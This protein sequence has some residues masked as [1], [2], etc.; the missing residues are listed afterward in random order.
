MHLKR[1]TATFI[2]P[3]YRGIIW[4]CHTF[5]SYYG[6][7]YRRWKYSCHKVKLFFLFKVTEMIHFPLLHFRNTA[8][9]DTFWSD[10]LKMLLWKNSSVACQ[11]TALYN[12][13]L[14]LKIFPSTRKCVCLRT[15]CRLRLQEEAN[16]SCSSAAVFSLGCVTFTE[17]AEPELACW[18]ME[19]KAALLPY[20]YKGLTWQ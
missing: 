5:C 6:S 10:F 2:C 7:G 19:S 4:G 18:Q 15:C 16:K 17:K 13:S 11:C 20:A 8:A 1:I 3:L 9:K 12:V 14:F